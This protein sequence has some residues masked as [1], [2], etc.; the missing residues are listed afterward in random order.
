MLLEER[1][2]RNSV[3]NSRDMATK[4]VRRNADKGRCALCLQKEDVKQVLL[5]RKETKHWREKLIS[6]KWLN[7]N[8][9]IACR[10]ITKATNRTHIEHI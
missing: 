1:K 10:K 4:R 7:T 9:E 3:A 2:E 6:D 8:K 5:E